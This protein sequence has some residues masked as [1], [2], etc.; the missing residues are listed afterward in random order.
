MKIK[1]ASCQSKVLGRNVSKEDYHSDSE[2]EL[3]TIKR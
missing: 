3:N 2:T 1:Y